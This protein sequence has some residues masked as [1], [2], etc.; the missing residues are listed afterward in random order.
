MIVFRRMLLDVWNISD[1]ICREIQTHILCATT[2]FPKS[3]LLL[4]IVEK[5]GRVGEVTDDNITRRMRFACSVTKTRNTQSEYVIRI[6][7]HGNNV[8][9]TRLS[10]AL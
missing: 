6:A 4:D 2:P 7:F 10:I 9:R 5:S 8:A 3:C 1:K